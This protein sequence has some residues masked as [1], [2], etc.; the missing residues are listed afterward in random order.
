MTREKF[1]L[2]KVYRNTKNILL[3]IQEL[4]YPIGIP[5]GIKECNNAGEYIFSSVF[6]EIAHIANFISERD[7]SS[8]GVLAKDE[9][10]LSEFKKAFAVLIRFT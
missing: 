9:K 6:D 5:D 1:F 7:F 2:Q 4:G 3:Y 10:Y 8:V